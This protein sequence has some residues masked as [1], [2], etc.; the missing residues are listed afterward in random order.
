[1][2]VY[3][4]KLVAN[5]DVPRALL[6]LADAKFKGRVG[7]ARPQFGTTRGH[8]AAIASAVGADGLRIWLEMLKKNDVRLLDGNA[9]VVRA[10]GT[11]E[12]HI[13]WTDTDDVIAGKRE[14]WPVEMAFEK[15]GGTTGISE[16]FGTLLLPNTAA[17][18]RG[19]PNAAHAGALIDYLLSPEA[20]RALA[21]SDS[22]NI[23]VDPALAQELT[24][25]APAP[26]QVWPMDFEKVAD[27]V[28][29]AMN[30]CDQVFG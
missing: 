27:S 8:V 12:I 1:M 29:A 17:L 6:G 5:A 2:F 26:D 19:G 21:V 23:P 28:E 24:T 11:G 9:S 22:A 10:V 4:T 15:R 18:V 14:G 30:V 7:I 16:G 20:Q 13:G 3:N 25:W